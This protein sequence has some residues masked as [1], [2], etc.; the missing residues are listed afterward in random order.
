MAKRDHGLLTAAGLSVA[1]AAKLF[2]RSRQAIYSGMSATSGDEGKSY[3]SGHD[4][5]WILQYAKQIDSPQL[6]NLLKFIESNYPH[7]ETA[8]VLQDQVGYEQIRRVVEGGDDVLIAFNGN[9]DELDP[10]STFAKVL[11]NLLDSKTPPH[12][13]LPGEWV[14]AYIEQRLALKAPAYDIR[15]ELKYLPSFVAIRTKNAVRAFFFQMFAPDECKPN[16]AEGLWSQFAPTNAANDANIS[17][18]TG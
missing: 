16:V 8:L 3:F 15:S 2:R 6:G 5:M 11:I 17:L 18:A 9:L 4:A 10:N 1:D 13:L 14:V 7:F 12:L